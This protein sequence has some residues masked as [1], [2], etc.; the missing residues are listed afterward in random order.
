M[1]SSRIAVRYSKSLLDIATQSSELD[2]VKADMDSVMD[3]CT[4]SKDLR[5][6]LK[7]PI[8]KAED[9]KAV[10]RKVFQATTSTTQGF[11]DFLVDKKREA[12]LP[13]VAQ[14]FISSYNDLNG[15]AEATVIS[16][17]ALSEETLLKIKSYASGLLGK[18]DIALKN[19]IDPSIIGGIV[20]KHEDK[21]LD[22]SVSKELREIRKTLIYN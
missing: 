8:V 14:N 4:D 5:N 11:I 19:E 10:L 7:N 12:E 15:I 13:M 9:K 16:A 1:T 3:T 21:L 18:D 22:M 2:K 6:L 20:I 17:V